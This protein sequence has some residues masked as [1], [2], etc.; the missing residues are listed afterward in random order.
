[1]STTD[2]MTRTSFAVVGGTAEK[3][4][5]AVTRL[6]RC[7]VAYTA[8]I[9][10]AASAV[11]VLAGPHRSNHG[12]VADYR[13]E[14]V[15]WAERQGIASVVGWYDEARQWVYSVRVPGTVDPREVA[16]AVGRRTLADVES[17]EAARHRRMVEDM[18]RWEAERPA[19]EAAAAERAALIAGLEEQYRPLRDAALAAGASR[20][21][22]EYAFGKATQRTGYPGYEAERGVRILRRLA[23]LETA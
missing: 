20:R 15:A 18:A 7:R 4:A 22:V 21:D 16:A 13:H 11:Y 10:D 23:G 3:I 9:G 19:R 12:Q 14:V 1:M 5:A 2:T 6:A 8:S 17:A